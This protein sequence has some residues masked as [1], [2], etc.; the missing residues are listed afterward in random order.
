MQALK[1]LVIVMGIAIVAA[2][3][4]LAYGLA[5][6]AAKKQ[7]AAPEALPAFGDVGLP[8]PP[9]CAI[10]EARVDG[11]RLV[12]RIDGLAERGCQQVVLLDRDSG[13]LLGRVRAEPAE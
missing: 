11:R 5:G 8:L 10:A 12:L 13:A 2:L 6:G 1:A 7:A 3:G 4:L 9:G